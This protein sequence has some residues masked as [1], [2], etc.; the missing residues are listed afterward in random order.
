MAES[1]EEEVT[2]LLEFIMPVR[3]REEIRKQMTGM[4]NDILLAMERVVWTRTSA[5]GQEDFRLNG[6]ILENP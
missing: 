4:D 6:V 3:I 1:K 5:E 2:I